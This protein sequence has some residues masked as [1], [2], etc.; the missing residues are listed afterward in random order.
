MKRREKNPVFLN[1]YKPNGISH[2]YQLD[3]SIFILR[4][5]EG[6]FS[7]LFHFSMKN[8]SANRI[9]PDGTPRFAAFN[10]EPFCLHM[11]HKKD[12]R[13]IYG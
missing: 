1:P 13:L 8:M 2:P 3:E 10:L 6:Y 9:A 5:I 7:I 11:S 12:T 4:G